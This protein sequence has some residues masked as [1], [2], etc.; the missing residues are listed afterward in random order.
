M[1]LPLSSKKLNTDKA[2]RFMFVMAAVNWL[3]FE[4]PL[5]IKK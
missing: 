1:D 2:V 5:K 3:L 4:V